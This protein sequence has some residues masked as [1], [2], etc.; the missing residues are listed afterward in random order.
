MKAIKASSRF[1]ASAL[2][3]APA[4]CAQ[5]ISGMASAADLQCPSP[6]QPRTTAIFGGDSKEIAGINAQITR[7]AEFYHAKY[8]E[9]MKLIGARKLEAVQ[10]ATAYQSTLPE[11]SKQY[12]R[13]VERLDE[14]SRE[15]VDQMN[16]TPW[17]MEAQA[18]CSDEIRS[19]SIASSSPCFETLLGALKE[20]RAF[21]EGKA[22]DI[23]P[24]D[25][26]IITM[27]ESRS[28]ESQ[29]ANTDSKYTVDGTTF[30]KLYTSNSYLPTFHIG[31]TFMPEY[32]ED[33]ENQGFSESN[34]FG[35]FSFDNRYLFNLG[36]HPVASHAGI[37]V[38][39]HSEHYVNCEDATAPTS[40]EGTSEEVH[41]SACNADQPSL[42][43]LEFNDIS[44]TVNATAY[45]W[46]H[47]DFLFSK[48]TGEKRSGGTL[49][50]AGPI[51]T[52]FG[53]RATLQSRD[54]LADGGDSIND[55]YSAGFRV[56]V[57]DFKN[58]LNGAA[59]NGLPVFYSEFMYAHYENYAEIE[60][61][62]EPRYVFRSAYRVL[63]DQPIFIGLGINGGRGPDEFAVTL[64]YG[65][66]AQSL[67][68]GILGNQ[69]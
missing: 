18:K 22:L 45:Y 21:V 59:R 37:V 60:N 56:V 17:I 32:N 9:E 34:V 5:A 30:G 8:C 54:D 27:E 57:Y 10:L 19:D 41:V 16:N 4:L 6:Y 64:S 66:Q 38:N 55:I 33:G 42:G 69:N 46:L 29:A 49:N 13:E 52:G 23:T 61:Y 47:S 62:D 48:Q 2:I 39:F 50:D 53:F 28:T 40:N 36:S 25:A 63:R 65:V 26:E 68:S 35:G 14:Q 20:E 67:F 12:T 58:K 44:N 7:I 11:V 3:W 1:K 43:D 15:I 24:L 31:A 51:E